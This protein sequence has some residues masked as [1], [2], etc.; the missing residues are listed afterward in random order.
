MMTAAFLASVSAAQAETTQI[1]PDQAA[2]R[3][4]YKELVET[5]TEASIGSCTKA[6][7]QIQAR[8]KKAGYKDS[9]LH[10]IVE[11]KHPR[12][13]NIVAILPGSDPSLKAL[14]LLAHLDVVEAKPADW[15]RD[16]FKLFEEG[17]YFYGRGTSDDK[18]QAAIWADTM[19]RFKQ[20]GYKPKRTVKMAL[21]CGEEG[22]SDFIGAQ[23]LVK[24][25]RDLID[26]A[27]ALNEG[28]AGKLDEH[29]NRMVYTI[30][31]SEKVY[32]D[33]TLEVTNPGGHSS[34]PLP[35]NAIYRLAGA[36]TRIGQ[37]EFPV[38]LSDTTR[39]YF[40][41][42]GEATGGEIGQAMMAIAKN[43]DDHAAEAIL[44]RNKEWHSMLRTTC[45]AT[46]LSG[47]HATNALPQRA[48]AN[49][50]CR[51]YPGT[52]IETVRDKLAEVAAD[53]QVSVTLNGFRSPT[54]PSPPL[55]PEVLGPIDKA[56][57]EF[58]PGVPV[59]PILETGASD[60]VFL[61][62]G[63]IPTYGVEGSFND[64]D[65]GNIHGL[66]E[67]VR[68]KSLYDGRDFLFK[69]VTMYVE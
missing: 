40:T 21:T 66:N 7:R 45:V 55:T 2:F 3:A 28:G 11:P 30:E 19:I 50:N 61:N 20:S 16:P 42:L 12:E 57:A 9:D 49:V 62:E 15:T 26:A 37:Y 17:G 39:L 27:F 13:G 65:G 60:G 41:R 51:I 64:P 32:Q 52:S 24:N 4:L 44:N 58:F 1:R 46:M 38:E 10:F 54:P 18:A 47:G 23:Y 29:G 31:T 6:A 68:V 43:P 8:L 48:T 14:L 36:L 67:R 63:G 56:A 59:L 35:D 53:P 22:G 34:Q 25:Y 69:L 33:F 5:N